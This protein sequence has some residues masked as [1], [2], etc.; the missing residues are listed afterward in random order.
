MI[1]FELLKHVGNDLE[2]RIFGHSRVQLGQIIQPHLV[3]ID[4][5]HLKIEVL[6]VA[7]VPNVVQIRLGIR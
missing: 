1:V 6:L 3:P 2:E 5:F 4:S 7:L